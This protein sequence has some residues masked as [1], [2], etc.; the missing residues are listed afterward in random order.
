M[1][2]C[3]YYHRL[4]TAL[5]LVWPGCGVECSSPQRTS[6][7]FNSWFCASALFVFAG[8]G[9]F[10]VLLTMSFKSVFQNAELKVWFAVIS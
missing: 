10:N 1:K 7:S 5:C 9:R 2:L 4:L 3:Y 8:G 6:F